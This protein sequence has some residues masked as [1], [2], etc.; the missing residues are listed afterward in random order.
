MDEKPSTHGSSNPNRS[1]ISFL[2]IVLLLAGIAVL[3]LYFVYRPS[4][5][6]FSLTQASI[7]ALMD[8]VSSQY[9]NTFSTSMQFTFILYNPNDR[10]G[11][12]YDRLATTVYYHN[13]LITPPLTLESIFQEPE[14]TIAMSPILE[15][16]NVPVSDSALTALK[17]D[18]AYG[19]V[20]LKVVM[21]GRVRFKPS[22]FK[23]GWSMLYV[24]CD[25]AVGLK[26]DGSSDSSISSVPLL[27]EPKCSVE[28]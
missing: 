9:P 8:N 28:V 10:V 16:S 6:H 15:G 12:F 3:V 5:P 23:I 14:G 1:L 27:N 18:R 24:R 25:V 17:V 19:M 13:E 11:I 7:S 22:P 4:K 20:G 2:L 26:K 21:L